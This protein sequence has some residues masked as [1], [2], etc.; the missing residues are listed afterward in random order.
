[1]SANKSFGSKKYFMNF[2]SFPHNKTN[3]MKLQSITCTFCTAF[4]LFFSACKD[5]EKETDKIQPNT[6]TAAITLKLREETVAYKIDTLN[7]RSYVVYDENI[8]GK[9]P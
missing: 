3:D 8:E 9:R 6:A 4:I 1:M 2:I 5:A 7:M